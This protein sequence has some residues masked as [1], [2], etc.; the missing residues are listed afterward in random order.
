M[1]KNG[2]QSY[3]MKSMLFSL[4]PILFFI[5]LAFFL[6]HLSISSITIFFAGAGIVLGIFT[7]AWMYRW[8]HSH[9]ISP[10]QENIYGLEENEKVNQNFSPTYPNFLDSID[11]IKSRLSRTEEF[12]TISPNDNDGRELPSLF[13]SP[14][15]K[16][17]TSA[18][19]Y[20]SEF[21]KTASQDIM[22]ENSVI[23]TSMNEF[24]ALK[25]NTILHHSSICELHIWGDQ[26][27]NHYQ[28]N[29]Q[30]E[31]LQQINSE[32]YVLNFSNGATIQVYNPWFIEEWMDRFRIV[33]ATRII[34]SFGT[35]FND[36][37]ISFDY[38]F[39]EKMRIS[40]TDFG[41]QMETIQL[42]DS[43][44]LEIIV[45]PKPSNMVNFV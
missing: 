9:L 25:E 41:Y 17:W 36:K 34:C 29:C 10:K 11:A 27:G 35:H 28:L 22:L 32:K 40:K 24:I 7:S 23:Y 6:L 13:Y 12:D 42:N 5:L 39:R 30:F 2:T 37:K 38:R 26:R 20:I 3:L 15:L 1:K 4:F 43:F 8:I 31:S 14:S 33:E 44:A 21:P 45:K 19:E 18:K 16:R